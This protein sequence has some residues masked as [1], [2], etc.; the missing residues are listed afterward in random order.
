MKKIIILLIMAGG[1]YWGYG[2]LDSFMSGPGAFDESG[3]PLVLLFT[4]NECGQPCADVVADLRSRGVAFEEINAGTDEG[5]SR[6]EKF[7]V[8]QVPLTVIGDAKVVGTNLTAIESALGEVTGMT[9][10]SPA[11]QQVMKNHFDAG[12]NPRVVL[13]GTTTCPYCTKMRSYLDGRKVAYEFQDVAASTSARSDFDI[14]RGRG[15]PLTYV[16]FRRID[17]YDVNKIDQAVKDLL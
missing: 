15:Y 6:I 12:G 14:L 3:K 8:M 5:R 2:N 16:G 10:Y 17:G 7:G 4:M 13:Y 9:A 11:V 1:A